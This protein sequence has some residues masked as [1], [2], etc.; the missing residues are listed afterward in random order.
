MDFDN[1]SLQLPF[2][3]K[4]RLVLHIGELL[5]Y[6]TTNHEECNIQHRLPTTTRPTPIPGELEGIPSIR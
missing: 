1:Y 4:A 3:A 5:P 6:T 2:Y